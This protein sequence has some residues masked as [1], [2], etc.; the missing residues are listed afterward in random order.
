GNDDGNRGADTQLEANLVRHVERAKDFVQNRN[1]ER[2]AADSE[3][4]R[5]NAR[6]ESGDND[7]SGEQQE[8]AH[9]HTQDHVLL[10]RQRRMNQA[11]A[12]CSIRASLSTTRASAWRNAAAYAAGFD[13]SV[14]RRRRM[15][16]AP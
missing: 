9:G 3:K 2:A 10:R 11:A 15:E 1:D 7:Q 14:G 12:L 8:L 4:P 5:E 6:D 16:R 13:A